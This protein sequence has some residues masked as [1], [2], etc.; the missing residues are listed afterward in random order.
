MAYLGGWDKGISKAW[1]GSTPS[2]LW[3]FKGFLGF[4]SSERLLGQL[5]VLHLKGMVGGGLWRWWLRTAKAP[6]RSR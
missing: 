6:W 1:P 5:E 4:E 3:A 2:G